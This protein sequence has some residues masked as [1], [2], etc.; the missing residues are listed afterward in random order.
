VDRLGCLVQRITLQQ[1]CHADILQAQAAP[2]EAPAAGRLQALL[3]WPDESDQDFSAE[4]VAD[5]ILGWTSDRVVEHHLTHAACPEQLPPS[6]SDRN[7]LHGDQSPRHE[8][9][10]PALQH[11]DNAGERSGDSTAD[12]VLQGL[13]Q[14]ALNAVHCGHAVD[15][16]SVA[17]FCMNAMRSDDQA[18]PDASQVL[19]LAAESGQAQAQPARSSGSRMQDMGH[20]TPTA[21]LHGQRL[22]AGRANTAPL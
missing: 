8:A 10:A 22:S 13:E 11:E 12:D 1:L 6:A 9:E 15:G 2:E 3:Q 19:L 17:S 14:S 16:E 7:V 21:V 18:A 4:A 5:R 20:L